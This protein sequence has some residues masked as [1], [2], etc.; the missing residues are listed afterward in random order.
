MIHRIGFFGWC[1]IF[2]NHSV[3]II[4]G[5]VYGGSRAGSPISRILRMIKYFSR[6]NGGRGDLKPLATPR[7]ILNDRD[8]TGSASCGHSRC[9]CDDFGS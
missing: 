4:D 6:C 8:G 3:D 9:G 7:S 1:G 5:G 2:A